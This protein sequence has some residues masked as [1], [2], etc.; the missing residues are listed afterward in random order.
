MANRIQSMVTVLIL[1]MLGTSST[2]L[3]SEGQQSLN[4]Q[5]RL[6]RIKKIASEWQGSYL[7]LHTREGDEFKGHL[8]EISNNNYHLLVGD[9]F[10]DIPLMD[11]TTVSFEPGL[12]ELMLTIAS[13]LMGSGFMGGAINVA[14]VDA[15][16]SDIAISA[17]IGLIG[18]GLWGYTTFYES[19]VFYLE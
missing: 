6:I 11:V 16:S 1:L 12:P 10:I 15:S 8:V 2:G 17:F 9:E 18:G 7:T 19:E 14:K 3:A 4:E 5:T 13:A